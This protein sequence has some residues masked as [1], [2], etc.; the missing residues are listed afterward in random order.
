MHRLAFILEATAGWGALDAC[1]LQLPR[2]LVN[3]GLSGREH[4][5]IAGIDELLQAGLEPGP[6]CA[7]LNNLRNLQHRN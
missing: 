2:E 7:V 3:P 4:Q 1:A 6:L 5:D